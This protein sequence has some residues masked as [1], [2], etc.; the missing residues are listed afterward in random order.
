M[1]RDIVAAFLTNLANRLDVFARQA[2]LFEK[3]LHQA[4]TGSNSISYSDFVSL[5]SNDPSR[6]VNLLSQYPGLEQLLS[7]ITTN[8]CN[9]A[10]EFAVALEA[11]YEEIQTRFEMPSTLEGRSINIELTDG[12]LHCSS[13]SI[14]IVSIDGRN[15]FG[16]K[17]RN[18]DAEAQLTAL[19]QEFSSDLGF[20]SDWTL[21]QYVLGESHGWVKWVDYREAPD[22]ASI[23]R[24]YTRAGYL[25]GFSELYGISDL[26]N[27]NL[28]AHGDSPVPVDMEAA[29]TPQIGSDG[30]EE[31][32][33]YGA[34]NLLGTGLLPSATWK[35]GDLVGIDTS[36]LGGLNSQYCSMAVYQNTGKGR[37]DEA[38]SDAGTTIEPSLNVLR[39]RGEIQK[40]WNYLDE[41]EAGYRVALTTIPRKP[42]AIVALGQLAATEMRYIHQSTAGYHFALQASVHPCLLTDVHQRRDYLRSCLSATS[43]ENRSLLEAEVLAC[44]GG[45]VPR[46]VGHPDGIEVREPAYLAYPTQIPGASLSGIQNSAQMVTS[47]SEARIAFGVRLLR[48]SMKA[49]EIHFANGAGYRS[50]LLIPPKTSASDGEPRATEALCDFGA[51]ARESLEA[52]QRYVERQEAANGDRKRLEWYGCKTSP[53]GGMEFG[54]VGTDLYH[55]SSGILMAMQLLGRGDAGDL[56]ARAT[57]TA[58]SELDREITKLGGSYIG[59]S[60]A[61][62]PLYAMSSK[63]SHPLA[64]ELTAAA[65]DKFARA[66]ASRHPMQ[67]F[68]GSDLICGVA[69]AL[70]VAALMYS[71]TA[72]TEWRSLAE[73]IST[74]LLAQVRETDGAFL[75]PNGKSVSVEE[76]GCLT[77]LSHG[78]IGIALALSNYA[79]RCEPAPAHKGRIEEL[80]NSLTRW[81]LSKYCV[82]EAN[83]PDYRVRSAA[84]NVQPFEFGWSHGGPGIYLALME[85]AASNHA[86]RQFTEAVPYLTIIEAALG[87]RRSPVNVTI[88]HGSLGAVNLSRRLLAMQEDVATVAACMDELIAWSRLSEFV[89]MDKEEFNLGDFDMPGLWTGRAGAALGYACLENDALSVPFL[90]D[91]IVKLFNLERQH[92]H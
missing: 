86:A 54:Q 38:F 20:H 43:S 85:L 16:Y 33:T 79:R 40:P 74:I 73:G 67:Y 23:R 11:D 66:V 41:L 72:D 24:F 63:V 61:I 53:S 6:V 30:V 92:A 57:R 52:T 12:E 4:L 78:Q 9:N 50:S 36:G 35:G 64:A 34:W 51:A 13:R 65:K 62:L 55:G 39:F 25:I 2:I 22:E 83:W 5:L 37:L 1:H 82:R 42:R 91:D 3:K 88:C 21:P 68:V 28:I 56:V 15:T 87:R 76:D 90:I 81:E 45:D 32:G 60:S 75:I 17:P 14:V 31:I 69:G 44:E 71:T 48:G 84:E 8:F 89:Q 26:H 7:T 49:L 70:N 77:G 27:G 58:I 19:L 18:L 80:V 47:V 29:L 46:F 59:L 10:F